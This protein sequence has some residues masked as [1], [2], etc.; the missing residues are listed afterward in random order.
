M[1]K[2]KLVGHQE[3]TPGLVAE[4][5]AKGGR[6]GTT[7]A[8]ILSTIALIDDIMEI[9]VA[10]CT[11]IEAARRTKDAGRDPARPVRKSAGARRGGRDPGRAPLEK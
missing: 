1:Q 7:I 11:E 9:P 2:R 4:E 10:E 6:R 8:N 3:K 5:A